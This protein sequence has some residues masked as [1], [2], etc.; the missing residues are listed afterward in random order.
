MIED[1]GENSGICGDAPVSAVVYEHFDST[2]LPPE[3]AERI[4]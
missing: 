3:I 1:P 4:A 2:A